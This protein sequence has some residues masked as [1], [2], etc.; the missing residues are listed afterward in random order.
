MPSEPYEIRYAAEAVADLRAMRPFDRRKVLDGIKLHLF[1]QPMF[2]SRSRI[3]AM[4]QPFW[5]QYRLRIDAFRIYYDVDDNDRIVNVLRILMK[6]TDQT[7]ER[8]P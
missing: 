8:S 2:V 1:H 6:T 3:K 7:P 4:I 5:S